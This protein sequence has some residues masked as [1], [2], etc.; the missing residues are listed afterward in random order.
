MGRGA[1][2]VCMEHK[3]KIVSPDVIMEPLLALLEE[4]QAVPLVISGSSMTPFL[5]PGR[6]T[7]YLSKAQKPIRKGDMVLYRRS[8]GRYVLHRVLKADPDGY[9]MIGDA[10]TQPEPGISPEQICAVV[11]AV[12]RKGRLLQS[13]SFW[14]DFFEKVWIRMVPV[15]RL[16]RNIYF[17]MKKLLGN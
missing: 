5:A 7:V 16:V 4:A 2:E 17:F 9:T 10:Q 1:A 12:R 3:V 8:N 13:G 11:T 15:R 6:D 14:W